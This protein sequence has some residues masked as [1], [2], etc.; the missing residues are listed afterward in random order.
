MRNT[1]NKIAGAAPTSGNS[2]GADNDYD[3]GRD[4]SSE[5]DA[6]GHQ[7]RW[8]PRERERQE[9][10]KGDSKNKRQRQRQRQRQGL[11]VKQIMTPVVKVLLFGLLMS[12]LDVMYIIKHLEGSSS[13]SATMPSI[14]VLSK[15]KSLSE[16]LSGKTKVQ[17]KKNS[18]QK[19]SKNIDYLLAEREPII[20]LIRDAGISFDPVTDADLVEELPTWA[21]VVEMYGPEPVIHGLNEGNCERFQAQ[22]DR[23]DHYI[24]TAGAFNSG[25]NLLS[26]LLVFN[27]VMPERMKKHGSL[28]RGIR[29]QVPWGKHSPAGDKEFREKHKTVKDKGVDAEEI[30]PLVTIRDPLV[31]LKSMCRHKY[32]A[33]WLGFQELDCPNFSLRDLEINVKYDGFFRTYESLIHLW[34]DYYNDYRNIDIPFLLVRFE[35]LVFHAEETT[36]RVCECGGGGVF[37]KKRGG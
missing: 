16:I 14:P 37:K 20:K 34:N 35:D 17:T 6:T 24:G 2:F 29:W 36:R 11:D 19:N 31:W 12:V 30:M 13:Q 21:D 1:S 8:Q 26:D 3:S 23:G 28:A 15:P 4:Y 27:C 9:R 25:T 32:T 18:K 33:R 7:R 5:G 22:T 10:R